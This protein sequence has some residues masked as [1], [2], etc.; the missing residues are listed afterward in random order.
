M[1]KERKEELEA[2]WNACALP[3]AGSI[4]YLN[5][6][7]CRIR[8]KEDGEP[9]VEVL[10]NRFPGRMSAEQW[11]QVFA[12]GLVV[13]KG[14]GEVIVDPYLRVKAGQQYVRLFPDWVEPDVATNLKV[15]HEDEALLIVDKPAPLPMHEGGRF[16]KNTLMWLM[17]QAWPELSA[18]YA[19]RL[20]AETSGVL[21]C[22]KGREHRNRVQQSFEEGKVGKSYLA[23]IQ[24]WPEWS[25]KLVE[26]PVPAE[27]RSWGKLQQATTEF[28]TLE[29][30]PDGTA[31]VEARPVTGRTHQIRVHLWQQGFPIVGDRLY[32]PQGEKGE[33]QVAGLGAEPLAL[34]SWKI[35]FPH[36]ITGEE[37]SFEVARESE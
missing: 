17:N 11:L 22:V 26:E 1:Q 2:R 25:Q 35:S 29:K 19:H 16:Y 24:G 7:P 9:F 10:A 23:R 21:V 34:R 12:D 33:V 31:L 36:P 6:R 28:C 15:V 20:D 3:L 13:K 30:Y 5:S 14:D 18:G 8:A 4:P 37:A 27:G 32:L